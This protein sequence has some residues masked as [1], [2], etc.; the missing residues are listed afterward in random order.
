MP[1]P[2]NPRPTDSDDN[3]YDGDESQNTGDGGDVQDAEEGQ[4]AEPFAKTHQ[5]SADHV[6]ARSF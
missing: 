5:A 2:T 6:S 1:T 3:G 4:M